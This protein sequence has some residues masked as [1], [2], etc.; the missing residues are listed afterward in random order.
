MT[1]WP[2]VL[3]A[4]GGGIIAAA[5]FG[6]MPPSLP[7]L[8]AD[9]DLSLVEGGWAVSIFSL[10]GLI[11]GILTGSVV[12]S[13][14]ARRILAIGLVL[15]ALGSI[16]GSFADGGAFL[17]STR[18]LEGIGFL[19]AAVAGGAL[20]AQSSSTDDLKL[21]LGLWS[22]YMPA[23]SA[24]MI[25]ASPVILDS[26]G[27][28]GLFQL[29]A[30]LSLF[31]AALLFRGSK[32]AERHRTSWSTLPGN[33]KTILTVP[34]PAILSICFALYTFQWVTLMVWLPSAMIET[35]GLSTSLAAMLTAI[36]VAANIIGNLGAGWIQHRGAAR[37]M[38][39]AGGALLMA[40]S[41]QGIFSDALPDL[42]RFV[43]CLI[44]SAAGG[45]LPG[46]ILSGAPAVSPTPSL[47]G[48]TN[49]LIVQGSH[50]G[51]MIG[52]PIV[53]AIVS[54]TGLWASSVWVM[55]GAAA[56]IVVLA[57]LTRRLSL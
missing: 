14:G 22:T 4:L 35:K 8:R 36:I 41:A 54:A 50:L 55:N 38:I 39:L 49:G 53:A 51:Q 33:F 17:L 57:F 7:D 15:L 9:L 56:A 24:L 47:I 44:F 1:R 48:T 2:T 30:G 13:F 27:W 20:I 46:A 23:G 21:S 52:P 32:P 37:W 42:I 40:L 29:I 18:A 45:M 19:S 5:H 12:D 25:L 34:G 3:L 31:W 28:R 6:K 11:F 16:L 26:F 10:I 43:L